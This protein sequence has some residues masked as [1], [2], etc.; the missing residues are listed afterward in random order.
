MTDRFDE[1][2]LYSVIYN[3]IHLILSSTDF[4]RRRMFGETSFEIV[5]KDFDIIEYG[6]NRLRIEY[7][8]LS[9]E[10]IIYLYLSTNYYLHDYLKEDRVEVSNNYNL[11]LES[12]GSL[13][14]QES[15][16]YI[17][18]KS[19]PNEYSFTL[20]NRKIYFYNDKYLLP[21]KSSRDKNKINNCDVYFMNALNMRFLSAM[22]GGIPFNHFYCNVLEIVM[23]LDE[24]AI[25]NFNTLFDDNM[26]SLYA[27]ENRFH[28]VVFKMEIFD[29][30]IRV[31]SLL[32][33]IDY[34]IKINHN[35]VY[36]N[37][38]SVSELIIEYCDFKLFNIENII[39]NEYY[40][41]KYF[42]SI[43]IN[44]NLID[45]DNLYD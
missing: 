3:Y 7:D 15:V 12:I 11:I 30:K 42:K 9:S 8:N 26:K 29:L 38:L 33:D 35:P 18:A 20:L 23:N 6:L 36:K 41:N 5:V 31:Q 4:I 2:E 40:E 17:S 22:I 14:N 34:F 10:P 24:I 32:D 39:E 45:L 44:L 25:N 1:R 19:E 37:I 28:S 21:F 43:S 16:L 13:D 27:I